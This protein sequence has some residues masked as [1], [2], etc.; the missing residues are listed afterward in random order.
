MRP[1]VVRWVIDNY[2]YLAASKWAGV[3]ALISG[4]ALGVGSGVPPTQGTAAYAA[5]PKARVVEVID[6][7]GGSV[8]WW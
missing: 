4:M 8:G 1:R 7:S 2:G 5:M 3:P 6:S